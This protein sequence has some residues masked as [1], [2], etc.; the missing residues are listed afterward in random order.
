ML[1]VGADDELAPLA[2]AARHTADLGGRVVL[3]GLGTYPGSDKTA[4][5]EGALLTR[6]ELRK[7]GP[8]FGPGGRMS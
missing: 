8:D 2:A 6:A 1:A 3:P 4:L 5:G 7:L